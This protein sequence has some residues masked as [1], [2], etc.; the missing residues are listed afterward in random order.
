MKACKDFPPSYAL[1]TT[2]FCHNVRLNPHAEAQASISRPTALY[3]SLYP[4][5]HI[6]FP[7]N[8][9]GQKL[10]AAWSRNRHA[11]SRSMRTW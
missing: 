5:H 4:S 3:L 10:A 7:F 8:E 11:D 1:A 2:V 9:L 6:V